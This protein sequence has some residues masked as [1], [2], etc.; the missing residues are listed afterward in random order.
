MIEYIESPYLASGSDDT[1]SLS[2]RTLLMKME[3]APLP[4]TA[5]KTI[6]DILREM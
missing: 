3:G 4:V 1:V 6:R 5:E 2:M